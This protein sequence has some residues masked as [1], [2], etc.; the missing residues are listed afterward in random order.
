LINFDQRINKMANLQD[1]D[2]NKV[3]LCKTIKRDISKEEEITKSLRIYYDKNVELVFVRNYKRQFQHYKINN[4]LKIPEGT[5]RGHGSSCNFCNSNG[6]LNVK[7]VH[8][9]CFHIDSEGCR[10]QFDKYRA[11]HSISH[12]LY[13]PLLKQIGTL[14]PHLNGYNAPQGYSPYT[15]ENNIDFQIA[16][17]ANALARSF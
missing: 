15:D 8:H 2:T 17:N 16:S 3:I 6:D 12:T 9:Y 10:E 5:S 4:R 1:K 13:I 14:Y 11:S 7:P